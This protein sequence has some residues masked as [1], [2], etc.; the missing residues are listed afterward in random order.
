MQGA[1][2]LIPGDLIDERLRECGVP[3]AAVG[4]VHGDAEEVAAFGVTSV[5]NP[6][7]VDRDTLFQIGSITKPFVATA[8]MRLV[9]A[10]KLGLDEPVRSYVPDL[11]LADE[12]VAS[13][14]TIRNLLNHTGG[15]AGDHYDNSFGRGD[16][17]LGRVVSTLDGLE[18]LTPVGEIF[19]YNNAGFYVLGRAIE[20]LTGESFEDAVR[21]LVLGPLGL[22][23]A[24]FFPEDVVTQR[25][26]V[27][28]HRSGVVAEP[29]TM[30]RS[31]A[32][33]GGLIA[34][35]PELLR[36]ARSHWES[37]GFLSADSIAELRRP[38]MRVTLV[39]GDAFP[40]F[41]E[42]VGL[43][44]FVFNR[45]GRAFMTHAGGAPGHLAL[46]SICPEERFALVVLT[47]HDDGLAIAAELHEKVLQEALGASPLPVRE[48]EVGSAD[49]AE[50]VGGY[51]SMAYDAQ[52][53]I[54]DG[55]LQLQIINNGGWPEANTPPMPNPP[56]VRLRFEAED[57]AI[58][59]D[60]PRHGERS[61][62]VRSA[63][64]QI[65]WYRM[66]GRLLRRV[67]EVG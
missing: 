32:P 8:I 49:L 54:A 60:P 35:V 34:S 3:G 47:N 45:D 16:D 2:A 56:P 36:Y 7:E 44:W 25:F 21:T 27:G 6:L 14:V 22:E 42:A 13:A 26:T 23:R 20:N 1:G 55:A 24:Y 58:T 62:F 11:R 52:L 59:V 12:A 64:G 43:S 19:S 41:G 66:D 46:I 33:A 63:D 30:P 4:V 15:W 48:I 39:S 9:E 51:H 61:E 10:G 67:D 65:E 40:I 29:W 38:Q 17:A 50:Y 28:H 18:Q 57:A 37:T 53:S 31:A 5:P